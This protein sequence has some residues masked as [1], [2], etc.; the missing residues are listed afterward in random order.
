MNNDIFL[1]AGQ[2]AIVSGKFAQAQIAQAAI[3]TVKGELQ[4]DTERG[5]PYFDSI[6]RS[7][8]LINVWRAY[9][10]E[11]IRQFEWV[12]DISSFEASVDFENHIINYTMTLVTSDGIVIIKGIDYSVSNTTPETDPEGGGGVSLV[13]NGVFYLPVFVDNGIQVYRQLRQYVDSLGAI[14]TDLSEQTYIRN[15]SGV[16]VPRPST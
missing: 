13:Q 4:F 1:F 16:F 2:L 3:L 15:S 12:N 14:T 9:V 10:M 6:F 11:R 5:I 8:K 7:P